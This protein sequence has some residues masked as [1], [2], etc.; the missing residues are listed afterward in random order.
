MNFEYPR[1][2]GGGGLQG[3][4]FVPELNKYNKVQVIES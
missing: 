3:F 1:P 4:V 2:A